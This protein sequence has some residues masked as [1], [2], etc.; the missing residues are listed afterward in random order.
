MRAW[1]WVSLGLILVFLVVAAGFSWINTNPGSAAQGADVLRGIF[2]DQAVGRLES[3]VYDAQDALQRLR[4]GWGG[5]QVNAPW[6]VSASLPATSASQ[7]P[8][9]FPHTPT[10][11]PFSSLAAAPSPS[12]ARPEPTPVPSLTPTPQWMLAAVPSSGK[13][14]GEGQW[15]P[16]ITSADGAVLAERTF[17]QP[18]PNRPF[19][20][21]AVVAFNLDRTR[22]HYV[23]G[24]EEPLSDVAIKRP[25]S[26]DPA[27][28]QSERLLAV[29]NGGFKTRHGHFGVMFAGTVLVPP[30][31]GLGT[32]VL[33]PDGSCALG[34]WGSDIDPAAEMFAWRQNGPLVVHHGEINPHVSDP[35]PGVWGYTIAETV[36]IWRSG[37]GISPDRRTL[38]YF[39]GPGL[40]LPALAQAMQTAGV[41][42]SI[43][44][45]INNYWVHFDQIIFKNGKPTTSPL[46]KEMG[47]DNPNRYLYP[48]TRD[49]FYLTQANP[50]SYP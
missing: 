49:F 16:F 27:D 34:A 19:A 39:A 24:T 3:A 38:Y 30:K 23:L 28:I 35:R 36:P 46:F 47:S 26:I 5:S 25:G 4:Y 43:Q 40:T 33:Y 50:S 48:Y 32:L 8:T 44:L 12:P 13:L 6:Q 22:L 41:D 21:V 20:I 10:A 2:G 14:K 7:A 18:D 17:L 11:T 15:T 37:I 31:P 9:A 1:M 42:N 45:D 29:F